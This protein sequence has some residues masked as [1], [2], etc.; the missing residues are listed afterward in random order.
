MLHRA[1]T[2]GSNELQQHLP[3]SLRK[4]YLHELFPDL[5]LEAN[6]IEEPERYELV[7]LR[8]D[9]FHASSGAD[10]SRCGS[11]PFHTLPLQ[12]CSALCQLAAVERH[13]CPARCE[14]IHH[15]LACIHGS[16][17]SDLRIRLT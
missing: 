12:C 16:L 3:D 11:L 4:Q 10:I 5:S 7:V 9:V 8:D 17:Q 13:I 2:F 6:F 14:R 1:V 15:E